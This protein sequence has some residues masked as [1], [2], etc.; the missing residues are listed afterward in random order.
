MGN[1]LIPHLKAMYSQHVHENYYERVAA[2]AR[3]RSLANELELH[4]L[5]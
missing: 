1:L 4:R 2:C 3:T 5:S